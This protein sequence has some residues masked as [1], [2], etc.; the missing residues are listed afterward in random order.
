MN[1]DKFITDTI[2]SEFPGRIDYV[3]SKKLYCVKFRGELVVCNN[4]KFTFLSVAA[5]K[6]S[7]LAR[8]ERCFNVTLSGD[9]GRDTYYNNYKEYDEKIKKY[10][11]SIIQVEEYVTK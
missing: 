9:I 4:G 5:A 6:S 7:F 8:Y 1:I 3:S 10:L 11:L 2:D